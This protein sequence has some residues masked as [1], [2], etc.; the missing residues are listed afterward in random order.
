M[1]ET[2][3][4]APNRISNNS[5]SFFNTFR[6]KLYIS[7]NIS[8]KQIMPLLV[9]FRRQLCSYG[10]RLESHR[11]PI[12][13]AGHVQTPTDSIEAESNRQSDEVRG[14]RSIA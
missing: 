14:Y 1:E 10:Y 7:M 13:A 3:Q 8:S 2:Y 4:A 6:V 11:S 9:E 12:W 5:I